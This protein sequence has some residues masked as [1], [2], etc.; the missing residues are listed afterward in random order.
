MILTGPQIAREVR[1]RRITILPFDAGCVEPNSYGFHLGDQL[2][3]YKARELNAEEAPATDT[4]AIPRGGHQLRPCRLYLASTMETMGSEH[5]AATLHAR[6][7]TSTMGL[8]I[9]ISAPLG[10][11]GAILP[12]TLEVT[13]VQ[14]VIVYPG[15][16]I[17]KIAFWRTT[18]HPSRYDGK[19]L[20]STGPVASRLSQELLEV[21]S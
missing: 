8:W 11:T 6:L 17:G 18:A 19:Y 7:S 4:I 5:Y 3:V 2:L 16:A 15:M 20:G 1:A 14:P 12:W 13:C 9:H 21:D 10:H